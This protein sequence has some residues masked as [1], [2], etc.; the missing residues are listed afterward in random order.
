MKFAIDCDGTATRYPDIFVALGRALRATGHTVYILTGIPLSV[1]NGIRKDNYLHLSDTSWYDAVL[2][3]D[4]YNAQERILVA[5]VLSGALDNHELVGI[6][7]R[8]IC[9]EYGIAVLF[10]DDVDNVRKRGYVPVFGVA[11]Q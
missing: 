9:S 7:K 10:D 4:L 11:K 1:F 5:D 6:F 2:T 3:S 8:R